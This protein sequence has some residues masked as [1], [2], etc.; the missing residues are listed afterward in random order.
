M[1]NLYVSVFCCDGRCYWQNFEQ[2]MNKAINS[3]HLLE[4]RV[5]HIFMIDIEIH[6]YQ[7]FT[8]IA[9]M[10][11]MYT[12]YTCVSHIGIGYSDKL[13]TNGRVMRF[14]RTRILLIDFINKST[15]TWV[16]CIFS[17][18]PMAIHN[19]SIEST[20]CHASW[21]IVKTF[22]YS[23]FSNEIQLKIFLLVRSE[24]KKINKKV[25][26]RSI[27]H[28]CRLALSMLHSFPC[29]PQFLV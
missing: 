12:W 25:P 13:I 1:E 27:R 5:F 23:T 14:S 11:C 20:I 4:I 28:E 2:C 9:L 10:S 6:R 18:M 15:F 3:N 19:H 17:A 7:T 26:N 22:F 29:M 21:I 16:S 8:L 24:K